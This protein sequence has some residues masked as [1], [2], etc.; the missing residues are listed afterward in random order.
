MGLPR[1]QESP[2]RNLRRLTNVILIIILEVGGISPPYRW[3]NRNMERLGN[4]AVITEPG[5]SRE[6]PIQAAWLQSL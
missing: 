2:P 3:R 6:G 5:R 4:L 1:C